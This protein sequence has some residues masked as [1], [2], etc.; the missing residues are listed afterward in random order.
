[1]KNETK[2]ILASII[3]TFIIYLGCLVIPIVVV[4]EI[5]SRTNPESITAIDLCGIVLVF[6]IGVFLVVSTLDKVTSVMTD[7]IVTYIDRRNKE[8]VKDE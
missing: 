4:G 5:L 2:K 7:Y 1:M 3:S 6:T 8:G